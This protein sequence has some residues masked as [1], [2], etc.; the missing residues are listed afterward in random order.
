VAKSSSMPSLLMPCS[1]HSCGP[2]TSSS[3]DSTAASRVSAAAVGRVW[4]S[5]CAPAH[6]CE[7]RVLLQHPPCARTRC[8]LGCRTAPLAG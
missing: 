6:P 1:R 2:S 8:L 4:A 5:A 7:Q 3:I